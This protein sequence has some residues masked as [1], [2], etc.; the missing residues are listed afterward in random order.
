VA[1]TRKLAAVAAELGISLHD[2]LVFAGPD[3]RSFRALGLL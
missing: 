1:A 2:H 3:C